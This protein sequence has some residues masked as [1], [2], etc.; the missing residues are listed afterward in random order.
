MAD[1]SGKTIAILATHGFEQSEL[2]VPL[3]RLRSMGA[4][5]EVVSPED[6]AIRGWDGGDWGAAVPV[7]RALG[8]AR[9][10][11]YDALVLPGG[12]INP[13]LLRVEPHAVA[14]V[15]AFFDAKKPL[16]A[17]CHAPWLLVEADVV[18]GRPITS[19]ASIRTDVENAGGVWVDE[20]VVCHQALVTS[21]NPGDL[22]AF[23]TKIAEEV[24]EGPHDRR[25]AA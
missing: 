22:D 23:V 12:Q 15:R 6:G 9:E 25:R 13:D 7:D 4:T 17:I 11:D 3:E 19:Y 21:R 14:L 2:M 5:V 24:L 10:A 20:P 1:L 16:A 18:R 8:Q